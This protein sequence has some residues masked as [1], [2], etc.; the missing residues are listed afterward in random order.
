[1]S[2]VKVNYALLFLEKRVYGIRN[3]DLL[4]LMAMAQVMKRNRCVSNRK[5]VRKKICEMLGYSDGYVKTLFSKFVRLGYLERVAGEY[6][7]YF[8]KLESFSKSGYNEWNDWSY[9][10]SKY[11]ISSEVDYKTA[12]EEE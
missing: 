9:Y 4:V 1:M 8:I 5:E 12:L 3:S 6:G 2:F 11:N 7:E 10:L